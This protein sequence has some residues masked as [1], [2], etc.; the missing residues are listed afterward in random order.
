MRYLTR[1]LLGTA[2]G[3]SVAG[4]AR[5]ADLPVKAKPVEYVKVCTLY[6]EGFFYIPGTDTC[7]KIGGYLRAEIDANAGGTFSPALGPGGTNAAQHGWAFDRTSDS[8]VTRTRA[9]WTFDSRSQTE[10]GTLRAY[11]RTGIQWTTGDQISSGTNA[12]A[13]IDRAFIQLGGLT[14]GKAVSFFD[15]YVYGIHSYQSSVIGSEGTAGNGTN[16]FAYTYQFG[17]GISATLSGEDSYSRAR[18]IVNVNTPGYFSVNAQGTF[19]TGPLSSQA[20]FSHPDIIGNLRIDQV[21][22]YLGLSAAAHQANALYYGTGGIA[23]GGGLAGL[24]TNGHPDDKWGWATQFGGVLNAPW[25]QGDTFGFQIAYGVGALGYVADGTQGSFALFQGGNIALG[26]V[27]D[28]VYGGTTAAD[29]SQLQLTTGW[30]IAAGYEHYWTP[31]LRT[32]LYGGYLNVSYNTAATNLI[33]TGAGL[34]GLGGGNGFT[35]SNCAPDFSIVQVGSRTIW[36]PVRNL[37]IG[38]EVIYSRIQTGFAGTAVVNANVAEPTQTFNVRDQGIFS[39]ILRFQ[40][41]F[42]P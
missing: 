17:N 37:D 6:G 32:S 29:G 40:R 22:G 8:L 42:W 39:G 1:L 11:S 41:N 35:P 20:G 33:C 31:A 3:I 19:N 36:N 13:Y 38:L 16:L 7:L 18:A 15:T 5:A 34:K 12:P 28:G 2:A 9:L 23:P 25:S 24:V 4:G 30:A 27:T 26:F 10:Y 14:V 21:W